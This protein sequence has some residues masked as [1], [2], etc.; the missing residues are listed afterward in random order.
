MLT[1]YYEKTN[2]VFVCA[3]PLDPFIL[4]YAPRSVQTLTPSG[5]TTYDRTSYRYGDPFQFLQFKMF[6]QNTT[7]SLNASVVAWPLTYDECDYSQLTFNLR[8]DCQATPPCPRYNTGNAVCSG[9]GTCEIDTLQDSGDST[10]PAAA[11]GV[12]DRAICV[13]STP[14]YGGYACE[15]PVA[16]IGST[17]Q[18]IT[19]MTPDS[20]LYY[21]VNLTSLGVTPAKLQ[22]SGGA[23]VFAELER[24]HV[25]DPVLIIKRASDPTASR[26][27]GV[28]TLD[29]LNA[30]GDREAYQGRYDFHS[31]AA[32]LDAASDSSQ[33]IYI[34]IYN[35][36]KYLDQPAA[37]NLT[38]RIAYAQADRCRFQCFDQGTCDV[39]PL[40][41]TKPGICICDS[42]YGGEMCQGPMYTQLVGQAAPSQTF[43]VSVG[44]TLCL[45]HVDEKRRQCRPPVFSITLHSFS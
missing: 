32:Y 39:G 27:F 33:L 35:S 28:P 12:S 15:Q 43:K 11:P 20:W 34:G 4:I 8:I 22:A 25:G 14:N 45:R 24:E 2:V 1:E 23:L 18:N 38:V 7:A 26:Y 29:D 41:D 17:T 6:K 31:A 36:I 19:S 44:S 37:F 10:P 13:C 40:G 30:L 16:I 5:S 9:R 3:D 21:R 42:G